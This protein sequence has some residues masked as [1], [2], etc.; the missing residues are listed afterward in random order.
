MNKLKKQM[1]E[2]EG[3]YSQTNSYTSIVTTESDIL[4]VPPTQINIG[5]QKD[6]TTQLLITASK[7]LEQKKSIHF[8]TTSASTTTLPSPEPIKRLRPEL[9]TL[10]S[11]FIKQTRASI[12]VEHHIEIL[13]LAIDTRNPP[14][15]LIPRVNPRIPDNKE[16][17]FLI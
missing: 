10:L 13:Q 3:F 15:G 7:K 16:I 4:L 17:N 6:K 8:L 9:N 5:S 2:Q 11:V 12:K 14:R 1:A